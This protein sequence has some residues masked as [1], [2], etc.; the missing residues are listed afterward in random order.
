MNGVYLPFVILSPEE[1]KH[2]YQSWLID[3]GVLRTLGGYRQHSIGIFLAYFEKQLVEV[4]KE[5]NLSV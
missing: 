2:Q 1:P 5:L 4:E 3:G